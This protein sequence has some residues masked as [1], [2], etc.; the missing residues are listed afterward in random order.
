MSV[1][2]KYMDLYLTEIFKKFVA[3]KDDDYKKSQEVFKGVFDQVKQKMGENC[4]YFSK[5]SSQVNFHFNI[6]I[7]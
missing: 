2:K 1:N 5:Y 7:F 6:Y 3:I 4:K